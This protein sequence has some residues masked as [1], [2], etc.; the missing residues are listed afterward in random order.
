MEYQRAIQIG[1]GT[2]NAYY[3]N[4]GQSNERGRV[5]LNETQK[6]FL[7]KWQNGD[8]WLAKFTKKS[9]EKT[10]DMMIGHVIKTTYRGKWVDDNI[11]CELAVLTTDDNQC[12]IE[13]RSGRA[14]DAD[15]RINTW[16]KAFRFSNMGQ[17]LK[18][19]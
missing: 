4:R 12:V 17:C 18:I 13:L 8:D 15:K 19:Q 9:S 16:K 3:N 6:K 5:E 2:W 10:Y 11:E 7:V 14:V 1:D